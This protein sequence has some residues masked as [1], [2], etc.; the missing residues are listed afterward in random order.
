MQ[1]GTFPLCGLKR[2]QKIETKNRTMGQ[3]SM[4]KQIPISK[5]WAIWVIEEEKVPI[6][7]YLFKTLFKILVQFPI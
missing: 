3:F 4:G 2:E 7:S 1:I 6:L 5:K